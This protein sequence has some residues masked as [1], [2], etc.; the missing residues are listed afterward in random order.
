M[1]PSGRNNRMYGGVRSTIGG[2]TQPPAAKHA[3]P[4]SARKLGSPINRRFFIWPSNAAAVDDCVIF[5]LGA[6]S[7]YSFYGA[8]QIP[9]SEFMVMALLP[10]LYLIHKHI[11]NL[12]QYK[13]FYLFLALWL[14]DTIIDDLYLGV[15]LQNRVKGMARIIFLGL[16]FTTLAVLYQLS[17]RKTR[18]MQVFS[19]SIAFVLYVWWYQ[20][21][22]SGRDTSWKFGGSEGTSIIVLLV[23]CHFYKQRR[24]LLASAI[25]W[26]L[27]CLNLVLAFRSQMGILMLTALFSLP[28]FASSAGGKRTAP[29]IQLAKVLFVTVLAG[30]VG[31]GA[32]K[33]ILWGAQHDLFDE[34][35]KEK[36]TS[37]E[38]GKLGVLVGGRPETLVAVQAIKDSPIVGHGSYAIDPK[39]LA[40]EAALAYKYGYSNSDDPLEIDN[41]GIPTHS[42]LT[43]AWVESGILGGVFWIY[44]LGLTL[45][46]IF[47]AVQ[48]GTMLTPLYCYL[49]LNF[50][51]DILYSPMGAVNRIW[52]SF[53]ILISLEL[54]RLYKADR[55]AQIAKTATITAIA[56]P[57]TPRTQVSVARV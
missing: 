34:A 3:L 44:V 42:H 38:S 14:L 49:L 12:T 24:Y 53:T 9:G 47:L 22:S 21:R 36:F 20:W 31:W 19:L 54:L 39:Y 18:F 46:G 32:N 5:L 56:K 40:I 48:T 6:T 16:D 43:L 51:W 35:T 4:T 1:A 50:L 10:L 45:Y 41:P 28:F 13:V 26:G 30:F 15:T 37:Q 2:N 7:I 27:A 25:S 52:N 23:A 17:K 33:A 55:A 29:H 11:W 57:R 8:G